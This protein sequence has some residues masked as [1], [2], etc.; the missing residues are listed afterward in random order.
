MSRVGDGSGWLAAGALGTAIAGSLCCV[1]PV[2]LALAGLSGGVLF[3]SLAPLRP[4][5][6]AATLLL[7]GAAFFRT[8]RSQAQ[9]CEAGVFCA[10]DRRS[11]QKALLWL[12]A[13]AALL[14]AAS[15]YL[16]EALF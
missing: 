3:V 12:L 16:V 2:V 13:G 6:L 4:W 1:G 5:L 11:R 7:L 15:P 9:E 14:A 8:Y 10:P